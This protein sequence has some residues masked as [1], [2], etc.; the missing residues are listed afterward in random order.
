MSPAATEIILTALVK[1]GPALAKGIYDLFQTQD[2][3]PEQWATLFA[4][5]EKSYDD[6]VKPAAPA[7]GLQDMQIKGD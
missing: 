5:A 3:T 7:V 4:T 6:Y 1:Y 2:P